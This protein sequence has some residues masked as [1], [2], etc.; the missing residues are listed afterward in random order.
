MIIRILMF[1]AIIVTSCRDKEVKSETCNENSSAKEKLFVFVGEKLEVKTLPGRERVNEAKF[2]AKYKILDKVCG[3]FSADSI[4]FEVIN[5]FVDS[6]FKKNKTLL[7]FL[8]KNKDDPNQKYEL[9]GY[10][11]Y[12]LFKTKDGRWA[13]PYPTD[14]YTLHTSYENTSVRPKKIDFEQEVSYDIIGMTMAEVAEKFP[15]PYYIMKQN[16][17]I[18]VYGNYVSELFQLQKDGV[19]KS[20]GIYGAPDTMSIKVKEVELQEIDSLK[21]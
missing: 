10:L 21:N 11:Y 7:L 2:L 1:T 17:A 12:D 18:A 3:D 6:S 4:V 8:Q 9:W 16:K 15:T 13:S 20:W 14:D 19:L 5:W